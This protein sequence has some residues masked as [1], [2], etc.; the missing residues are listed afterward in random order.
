MEELIEE[1]PEHSKEL[2]HIIPPIVNKITSLTS[3]ADKGIILI[4]VTNFTFTK[5]FLKTN[6]FVF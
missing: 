5:Y 3:R 2:Q 1:I 4:E 6:V